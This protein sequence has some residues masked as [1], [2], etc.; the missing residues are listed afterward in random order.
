MTI[1]T[2]T[3]AVEARCR[4]IENDTCVNRDA[5]IS[6]IK[7]LAADRDAAV[8]TAEKMREALKPFSDHYTW[9]R[10]HE[11]PADVADDDATPVYGKD[12]PTGE[13]NW[14]ALYVGDFRRAR[15]AAME[16]K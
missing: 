15:A 3:E 4:R 1:D 10:K 2:S 8:Q 7:A 6:L 13:E 14:H 11:W 5:A 16:G 9:A 12:D